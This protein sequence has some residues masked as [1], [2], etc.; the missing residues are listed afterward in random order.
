[1]GK[2]LALISGKGGSGKTTIA[3]SIAS[4]LSECNIKT[5]LLDC[6][7]STNGATY[8]Y[9]NKIIDKNILSFSDIVSVSAEQKEKR[10]LEIN[11]FCDFIPSITHI[12]P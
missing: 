1:M 2:S 8:F 7:L 10:I 6:D 3:L 4:M 5:L 11:D 12:N 9:E